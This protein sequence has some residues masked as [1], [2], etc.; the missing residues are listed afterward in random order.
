FTDASSIEIAAG[1]TAPPSGT[2][3]GGSSPRWAPR[4]VVSP[5]PSLALVFWPQPWALPSSFIWHVDAPPRLRAGTLPGRGGRVGGS[6]RC[7]QAGGGGR[8]VGPPGW[9]AAPTPSEP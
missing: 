1:R 4:G 8:P 6:A 3:A 7:G 5:R 2:A 9:P